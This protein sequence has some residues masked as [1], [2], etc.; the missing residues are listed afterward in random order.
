[1]KQFLNLFNLNIINNF[2]SF[3]KKFFS[4]QAKTKVKPLKYLLLLPC[5]LITLSHPPGYAAMCAGDDPV[6]CC[7]EK[8]KEYGPSWPSSDSACDCN[9]INNEIQQNS[10]D[11]IPGLL[12]PDHIDSCKKRVR[13]VYQRK[14]NQCEETARKIQ[15]ARCERICESYIRTNAENNCDINNSLC[16]QVCVPENMSPNSTSED[17]Y[18]NIEEE[19]DR[20]RCFAD[21]KKNF[22]EGYTEKCKEL[23]EENLREDEDQK[24]LLCKKDATKDNTGCDEYCAAKADNVHGNVLDAAQV[25][26]EYSIS[27]S[28][29]RGGRR[30]IPTNYAILLANDPQK[31]LDH[32]ISL[33]EDFIPAEEESKD[34]IGFH[35]H[36][37]HPCTQSTPCENEIAHALDEAARTCSDLQKRANECCEEPEQCVGGGLAHAL[38]GLGK[39]NLAVAGMKG[40]KEQCK[41]VQQT[42]G[43]YAGMQ[44]LMAS[45]CTKTANA[46]MSECNQ[47]IGQFAEVYKKHCNHDPRNR[48]TWVD[49]Q[50]TCDQYVFEKYQQDYRSNNADAGV[51]VSRV[52]NQCRIVKKEANRRIQDM[53]TNMATGLLASM[54]ECDRVAKEN[55]WDT[56][57]DSSDD[58]DPPDTSTTTAYVPPK[59]IDSPT[60]L[61]GP[62]VHL[63]GGGDEETENPFTPPDDGPS[64][65][66]A[67][68]PFDTE[69]PVEEPPPPVEEGVKPG[70]QG[71][72]GGSGSGGGGL[73]GLGSGGGGGAG[74]GYAGPSDKG[75]KKK[76]LLG[77]K[78]G[79]FGGYGGGSNSGGKAEGRRGFRG[80]KKKGRKSASLDLKKLLP[81]GKQLNHK[82]G[83]YGSPHDDIFQRL[84]D[85]VQWMCK[86]NKI[87]CQ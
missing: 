66:Q 36:W 28:G 81:K 3:G 34:D 50:H 17:I 12:S 31:Q 23:I 19:A 48:A 71:M 13:S 69:P 5:F 77:F 47:A 37:F 27:S 52:H 26:R 51:N 14:I 7:H 54:E 85:R 6:A 39:L 43:M 60:G 40:M 45:R 87:K 16:E 73:G 15:K 21:L 8:V 35:L 2:S 49:G 56:T 11:C 44:G 74:G 83:R 9:S 75:K 32:E 72:L 78:G 53:G 58:F 18:H 42:H 41:A 24:E 10:R 20:G 86:T 30:E 62:D 64:G 82:I 55:E 25:I 67:A 63:G 59:P 22:V 61:G 29:R 4:T 80:G 33:L 70:M 57:D 79:K 76:V 68:N 84:S 65:P 38:D 46:C 1:M